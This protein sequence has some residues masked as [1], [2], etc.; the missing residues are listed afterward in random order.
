MASAALKREIRKVLS[1]DSIFIDAYYHATITGCVLPFSERRRERLIQIWR[2][3][4][5]ANRLCE[6]R[7]R[8]DRNA[9][10][11]IREI[12]FQV[13]WAKRDKSENEP[14]S[15]SLPRARQSYLSQSVSRFQYQPSTNA[16]ECSAQFRSDL[17][18]SCDDFLLFQSERRENSAVPYGPDAMKDKG[19]KDH[20]RKE[21]FSE[22][23]ARQR[24]LVDCARYVYRFIDELTFRAMVAG[25]VAWALL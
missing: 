9:G 15:S 25:N 19:W 21:S 1:L 18:I 13:T 6:A 5:R 20:A 2:G 24:S 22:L 10:Y 7:S 11:A 8:R 12:D 3:S 4:P 16:S 14:V 23:N 17:A